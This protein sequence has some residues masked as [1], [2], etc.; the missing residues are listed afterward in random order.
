MGPD[1]P[2]GHPNVVYVPVCDDCVID[3]GCLGGVL[4]WPGRSKSVV[5]QEAG[6]RVVFEDAAHI[7]HLAP[8]P[9]EVEPQSG[10]HGSRGIA[11]SSPWGVQDHAHPRGGRQIE[12][13]GEPPYF[14]WNRIPP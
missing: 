11:A 4:R 5:D 10:F 9:E 2:G 1:E 7:A 14:H 12:S 6:A 13:T 3:S 8:T